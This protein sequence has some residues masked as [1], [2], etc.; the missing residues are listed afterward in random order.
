LL[1]G[2]WI[3]RGFTRSGIVACRG[4]RPWPRIENKGRLTAEN[5]GLWNGVR[6]EV[7]RNGHLSIG[8]GTYL[9]RNATVVCDEHVSIGRNCA[10]SWDVVILDTDQHEREGL[11]PSTAPV[12]IEDDVWIGCRTIVLKG[13]T[14]GRGAVVGAGSIVTRDVP[15]GTLVVGQ[16]A[17]VVRSLRSGDIASWPASSEQA[18]S[19]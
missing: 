9:N 4:G 6:I 5:I 14:I 2:L 7:G 15:A 18:P 3:R 19:D 12:V 8:T 13:V 16:P 11:G 10:I 17:R 1:R